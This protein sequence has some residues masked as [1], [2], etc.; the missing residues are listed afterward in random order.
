MYG[1]KSDIYFNRKH[2]GFRNS[3]WI[4]LVGFDKDSPDYGVSDFLGKAGFV[5]DMVSFHLTS[6]A[7]VMTHKGM[8]QEHLLPAYACS[9]CGHAGNDDRERQRW[10]N[11]DMRGLVKSLHEH[12]VQVYISMF[13]FDSDPELEGEI[14]YP[15]SHPEL[16]VIDSNGNATQLIHMLKRFSDGT[17]FE[18]V[19]IQKLREVISD[20]S[21]DGI[22]M[23]DGVSS[24]RLSLQAA[25][26]SDE[27]TG[28]FC[29]A[30]G[31]A[32]P[33]GVTTIPQKAAWIFANCRA[34][35]NEWNTDNWAAFMDHVIKAI[36]DAGAKAAFNSAWTK[37]PVEALYR[38]GADYKRYEESGADS[39]IVEDVA[40][41]LFF[42]SNGDNGHEMGYERRKFIHYEFA[43]NMMQ[44]KSCLPRLRLTPLCM[45]RDTLEQWD[46]LHH[47]PTAMQRAVAVNLNNYYVT[48]AG[49]FVPVT[50]G[51]HYCLGDGLTKDEWDTIRMMWDTAWTE[52]VYDVT[53]VTVIWSDKKFRREVDEF[54]RGRLWY[55]GKWVA[56]LLKHGAAVHKTARIENLDRVTGPILVINPGLMEK[57]ELDMVSSYAGGEVYTVGLHADGRISFSGIPDRS[58]EA[59]YLPEST[60]DPHNAIWTASLTFMDTPDEFVEEIARFI[61]AKCDLPVITGDYGHCHVNQVFTSKNTARLF[62]D[63]EEFFYA[64]PV[65]RTSRRIRNISFAT[66]PDCYP[67]RR[68][69]AN[70]FGIRVPGFGMDIIEIEYEEE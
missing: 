46:V 33:D 54:T 18:T 15:A 4:E 19:F 16:R 50:N 24:P 36:N 67:I 22:Q 27:M 10:T 17:P 56:E 64:T 29:E 14:S 61:N 57:D 62:L 66:K 68:P 9:Y 43:S 49:R 35:W 52:N 59:R 8:E 2:E 58:F 32:L 11:Y 63:N 26:W 3:V 25:D 44:L 30:Y 23:A 21:L 65:V 48:D 7:F 40:A 55:N 34:K 37:G 31:I 5:P 28:A 20:Y 60:V 47:M 6:I 13:D 39:F 12:G 45:I 41:D 69:D 38:Y 70:S 51:P 1:Y 42:L 53:G